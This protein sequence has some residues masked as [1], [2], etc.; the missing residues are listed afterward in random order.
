[1]T[2]E[3][4]KLYKQITEQ[5]NEGEVLR[6]IKSITVKDKTPWMTEDD[7]IKFE[8]KIENIFS[9][10]DRFEIYTP[11]KSL[12]KNLWDDKLYTYTVYFEADKKNIERK[13]DKLDV[14]NQAQAMT[15][16]INKLRDEISMLPEVDNGKL[17]FNKDSDDGVHFGY[18]NIH[19]GAGYGRS[20]FIIKLKEKQ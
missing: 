14:K 10:N 8:N 19:D 12:I 5:L 3:F 4:D 2:C 18:K 6:P 9:K 13:N 1:M 20:F 15:N 16:T 7:K 11:S 17:S